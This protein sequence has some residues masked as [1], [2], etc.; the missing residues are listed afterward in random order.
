MNNPKPLQSLEA[1]RAV[2]GAMLID[3]DCIR[4]VVARL[5]DSDFA[6]EINAQIY[7]AIQQL[8]ADEKVVDAVVVAD[9]LQADPQLRS[10]LAELMDL[11]P[12]SANALEYAD[13]VLSASRR[14][15][16]RAAAQDAIDRI[17]SNAPE[18]DILPD[19]ERAVLG[20]AERMGSDLLTPMQQVDRY[21]AHRARIDSGGTAYV[22]TGYHLLDRLLGGGLINSGL[23]FLAARPAM[24]KTTLALNIAEKAAKISGEVLVISLEMS[25]DQIT[26]KRIS[27]MVRVDYQRVLNGIL[28][29]KE[30][31]KVAEATAKISGAQIYTNSGVGASVQKIVNMARSRKGVRLVIVDHFSLIQV[32]GRR[33][34]YEEY[35]NVS[36]ALKRLARALDAPVLC[37]AQL[38][39]ANEQR[40]DKRPMMSDL[41]DTGAAEQDADGILF[42]HRPGYYT[43]NEEDNASSYAELTVAK[44]RHG[45]TGMIPMSFYPNTSTFVE[46]YCR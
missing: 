1:E 16:L 2:L 13:M 17:D 46:K 8:D 24:G 12:T 19:L 41:R 44:N 34:R 28:T 3:R 33:S 10:Y 42:L 18:Q 38:N 11:T 43:G 7:R 27:A 40:A 32:P 25:D 37:L 22:R 15:L 36:A 29:Q 9:A 45:K 39:R 26:A 35:T 21:Y 6:L 30:Y 31:D 5:R 20:T 4:D 14:R 23:Y